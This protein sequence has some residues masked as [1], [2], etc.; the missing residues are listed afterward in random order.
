MNIY[1]AMK[2]AKEKQCGLIMPDKFK[3]DDVAILFP[4]DDPECCI[5]FYKESEDSR[6]GWMPRWEPQLEDFISNEW[7]LSPVS[8]SEILQHPR[9][10]LRNALPSEQCPYRLGRYCLASYPNNTPR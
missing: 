6:W 1:E 5:M 4:T 2:Q 8:L 7:E 9:L 3:F 10:S